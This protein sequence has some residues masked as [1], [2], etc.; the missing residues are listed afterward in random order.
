M[1]P[2]G[3]PKARK[4]AIAGL[5]SVRVIYGGGSALS[6]MP[7]DLGRNHRGLFLKAPSRYSGAIRGE[8]DGDQ[9][10]PLADPGTD[11]D[12]HLHRHRGGRVLMAGG[13]LRRG[14]T[15]PGGEIDR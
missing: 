12:L 13:G 5:S 7:R 4:C 9:S 3:P 1:A 10:L 14:T 15:Q 2:K 11:L 8:R 6:T